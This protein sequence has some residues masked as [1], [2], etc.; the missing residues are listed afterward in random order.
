MEQPW[1]NWKVRAQ[2]ITKLES[3]SI[4]NSGNGERFDNGFMAFLVSRSMTLLTSI[5]NA[6]SGS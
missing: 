6:D 2:Y 1:K 5:S 3:V 4:R